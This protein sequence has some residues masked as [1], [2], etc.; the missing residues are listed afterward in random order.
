MAPR[1]DSFSLDSSTTGAFRLVARR[2]EDVPAVQ[3]ALLAFVRP[4]VTE[5]RVLVDPTEAA[6]VPE[7]VGRLDAVPPESRLLDG[8]GVERVASGSTAEQVLDTLA[9]RLQA[10][11]RLP[12]TELRLDTPA[13]DCWLRGTTN[14]SHVGAVVPSHADWTEDAGP[15]LGANGVFV[16]AETVATW[17]SD[18][19]YVE[20]DTHMLCCFAERVAPPGAEERHYVTHHCHDLRDLRGVSVENDRAIRLEWADQGVLGTVAH[21]VFGRPPDRLTPPAE[22]FEA[23]RDHL[24]LF[25]T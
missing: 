9:D 2:D 24:A 14:G 1:L 16:P 5:L 11:N 12:V 19:A 22:S 25:V 13:A 21:A 17:T 20:I 8:E 4:D 18:D 15:G 3:R 6:D 23:V 7:P 10:D